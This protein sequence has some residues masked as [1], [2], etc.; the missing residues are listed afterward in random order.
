MGLFGDEEEEYYIFIGPRGVTHGKKVDN[1]EPI[2]DH[3][4]G[5]ERPQYKLESSERLFGTHTIV[6]EPERGVITLDELENGN[7]TGKKVH[8]YNHDF[9]SKQFS[10][11]VLPPDVQLKLKEME[12][13]LFAQESLVNNMMDSLLTVKDEDRKGDWLVRYAEQNTQFKNAL[14][15]WV[16]DYVEKKL[17]E[18][19]KWGGKK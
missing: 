10:K 18:R 2:F 1:T 8:V 9:Y 12:A 5:F 3:E 19:R 4:K 11:A 7:K 16:Q 14:F 13:Q 17:E 6:G 15:G